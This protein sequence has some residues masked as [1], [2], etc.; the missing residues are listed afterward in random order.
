MRTEMGTMIE[1]GY[2]RRDEILPDFGIFPDG[3]HDDDSSLQDADGGSFWALVDAGIF[4]DTE[5]DGGLDLLD[6]EEHPD[7][8]SAS[9]QESALA[10]LRHLQ[11]TERRRKVLSGRIGITEEDF[12][13]GP[14]REAFKLLRSRCRDTFLK[15]V[16]PEDRIRAIEWVFTPKEDPVAFDT[17]CIALDARPSKLQLRLMYEY[18]CNWVK[19][20][21]PLSFLCVPLPEEIVPE[22]LYVAGEDGVQ[23]ASVI[24]RW[25]GVTTE[26][27]KHALADV[28]SSAQVERTLHLIDETG[29]VQCYIE[30]WYVTGKRPKPKTV[31]K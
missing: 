6:P 13:E 18:F 31:W 4:G 21:G 17:C 23:V 3:N 9:T 26:N 22:L 7:G 5:D 27:I 29:I 19:F 2:E 28:M 16:K 24:W 8:A 12:E 25:P 14:Q 1:E 11:V 10:S 20:A 15:D 30:S